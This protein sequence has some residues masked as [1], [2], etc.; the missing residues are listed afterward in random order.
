MPK[1]KARI[2]FRVPIDLKEMLIK[3]TDEEGY[4]SIS[5]YI[6]DKLIESIEE[7]V[8]PRAIPIAF[9]FDDSQIISEVQQNRSIL[10]QILH[11]QQTAIQQNPFGQ[12]IESMLSS[13]SQEQMKNCRT[14]TELRSL[15]P[16]E[17]QQN[18]VYD[19]LNYLER[20]KIVVT[21]EVQGEERLYWLED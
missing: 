1:E 3:K 4:D 11:N 14:V 20:L 21:K 9:E 17:T 8:A 15:F 18:Y 19:L 13:I 5:D 6:R 12:I 10:T 2:E 16:F 7:K